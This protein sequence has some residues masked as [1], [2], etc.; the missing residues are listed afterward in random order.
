MNK[1][2]AFLL[3]GVVLLGMFAGFSKYVKHGG[4]KNLDFTTTVKFQDN[5]PSRF[6]EIMDDG[7]ILADGIV[8]STLV[9]GVAVW[10]FFR[11]KKNKMWLGAAAIPLAFFVLGV[12]EIYGKNI[13]PHPGPPFFMIKQPTTIFPKFHVV[14]P[15]SYPSGHAARVTFLAVIAGAI[16]VKRFAHMP[17][18]KKLLLFALAGYCVFVWVSRIYLGH[19]W[20]SDIVGGILVGSASALAAVGFLSTD[21]R[22]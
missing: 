15:Y 19:H 10:V 16:I 13:L 3:A 21:T 18:K 14:Q 6:D 8:S 17:Q 7:A 1:V 9:L 4:F 22:A 20:L 5:I 2:A 11:W 12:L